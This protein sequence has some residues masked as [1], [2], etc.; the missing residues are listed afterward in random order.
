MRRL[1]ALAL[2]GLALAGAGCGSDDGADEQAAT[3]GSTSAKQP[4]ATTGGCREVQAP[5]PK[6]DGGESKPEGELA[7]GTTYDVKFQ[8]S[9]GAFT[10]RLD[11]KTSPATSASFA[12][13]VKGGFFD[14]TVFH[15]IVPDFVIQGGD[16]TASGQGG[17]GY[18]TVDKPPASTA[19]TRGVVAMAKTQTDPPGTAGS[20]F[21]VVTGAEAPLPP[22]YAVLGKVVKGL[23]V[24]QRIGQLGDPAT[25]M[26]LQPVV[27][28]KAT[29]GEN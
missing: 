13:L 20:Q 23:D 7:A 16:P 12:A 14:D 27:V 17:P 8:T 9:C 21:Y 25:E 26:P 10:I 22:D 3:P 1:A 6:P 28:E 24:T 2:F 11:Q 5:A 18:T 29:L 15:R 4:A 19:Y